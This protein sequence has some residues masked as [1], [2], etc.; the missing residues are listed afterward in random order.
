MALVR[1]TE[2]TYRYPQTAVPALQGINLVVEPGE[3]VAVIGANDVGKSTLCYALTG[4]VPHFF[5]GQMSGS[6]QLDGIETRERPLAKLVTQAGLVFQNP[7]TQMSGVRDTV[8]GE[9]GF[10]LENLGIPRAEMQTRIDEALATTGTSDLADRHPQ[11]LSGGQQQRV[12]LAA[13]LAM[14]PRLLVL[15]EPTAQLDPMGSRELFAALQ[16]LSRSGLTLVMATHKLEWA[17]AYADRILLLHEGKLALQGTPQ[18]VLTRPELAEWGIAP[19]PFTEA[20]RLARHDGMWREERPLPI[21]LAAAI[22][23]FLAQ[24]RK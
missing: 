18:A 23:G 1:I 24:K 13:M 5:H 20:A 14:R 11:T 22:A 2:L 17:A 3:F 12:A 19:L 6:V 7:A 10:G 15:D 4:Y 21:T 9:V 8:V 16:R